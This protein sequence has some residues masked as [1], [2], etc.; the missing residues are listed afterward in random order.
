MID[1]D[2][3]TKWPIAG[4][5]VCQLVLYLLPSPGIPSHLRSTGTNYTPSRN[6]STISRS[7]KPPPHNSPDLSAICLLC[8]R[9]IL[10]STFIIVRIISKSTNRC[11]R[12]R[13][14]LCQNLIQARLG[15]SDLLKYVL[16]MMRMMFTVFIA[17]THTKL[18]MH[19]RKL[20]APY[21]RSITNVSSTPH[22]QTLDGRCDGY[23]M[24]AFMNHSE[25]V[26]L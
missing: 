22:F 17:E 26:N 2:M 16:K 19:T 18:V 25:M 14:D 9:S 4:P 24:K 20:L 13:L 11:N 21:F 5:I 15:G 1:R 6:G 10:H 8:K 7:A 23:V 12:W 3:L